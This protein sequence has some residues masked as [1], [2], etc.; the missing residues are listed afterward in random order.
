MKKVLL[1]AA[2][3][4]LALSSCKKEKT[5]TCTDINSFGS[6]TTTKTVMKGTPKNLRKQLVTMYY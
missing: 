4:V 5:C 2:V 1:I 6:T 3:A